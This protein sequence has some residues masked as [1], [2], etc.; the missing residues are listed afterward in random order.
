MMVMSLL[1]IFAQIDNTITKHIVNYV[2]YV[3]LHIDWTFFKHKTSI[4]IAKITFLTE[5]LAL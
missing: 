3:V 2:T 1:N 4:R 5:F